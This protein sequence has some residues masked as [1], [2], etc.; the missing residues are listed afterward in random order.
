MI[1]QLVITAMVAL[2]ALGGFGCGS[3]GQGKTMKA[4]PK[5]NRS[6]PM[7]ASKLIKDGASQAK[8]IQKYARKSKA[9]RRTR[10]S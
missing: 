1:R 3:V 9:S 5:I 2:L 8:G 10:A 4:R 7:M 6:N